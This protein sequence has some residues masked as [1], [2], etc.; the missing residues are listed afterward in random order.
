MPTRQEIEAKKAAVEAERQRRLETS[1]GKTSSSASPA[2]INLYTDGKGLDPEKKV[3]GTDL[4]TKKIHHL[5]PKNSSS[6]KNVAKQ[7]ASSKKPGSAPEKTGRKTTTPQSADYMRGQ[8]RSP[9]GEHEKGVPVTRVSG[10]GSVVMAQVGDNGQLKN[11]TYV[12]HQLSP[13]AD[14][15]LKISKDLIKK[16][17][18]DLGTNIAEKLANKTQQKSVQSLLDELARDVAAENQT[19]KGAAKISIDTIL[20]QIK[21]ENSQ[22]LNLA[23]NVAK[24]LNEPVNNTTWS[25]WKTL[26]VAVS[27]SEFATQFVSDFLTPEALEG[28]DSDQEFRQNIAEIED[29]QKKALNTKIGDSANSSEEQTILRNVTNLTKSY[30]KK[31]VREDRK[32]KEAELSYA[33][34]E[35][36]GLLQSAKERSALE[37]SVE[38]IQSDRYVLQTS[39]PDEAV[40]KFVIRKIA[41]KEADI[42]TLTQGS[43][44]FAERSLRLQQAAAMINQVTA[45]ISKETENRLAQEEAVLIS[46]VADKI[47]LLGRAK[48]KLTTDLPDTCEEVLSKVFNFADKTQPHAATLLNQ[49]RTNLILDNGFW[50]GDESIDGKSWIENDFIKGE[51]KKKSVIF[52]NLKTPEERR[53]AFEWILLEAPKA[54]AAIQ[55]ALKE[56]LVAADALK[57]K[58]EI[59]ALVTQVAKAFAP[60]GEAKKALIRSGDNSVQNALDGF[61]GGVSDTER[62]AISFLKEVYQHAGGEEDLESATKRYIQQGF[63][64]TGSGDGLFAKISEPEERKIAL[65]YLL[66][67]LPNAVSQVE[68]QA[69]KKSTAT[70][71]ADA[72]KALKEV[73]KSLKILGSTPSAESKSF[74]LSWGGVKTSLTEESAI[75]GFSVL[76]KYKSLY[77]LAIKPDAVEESCLE[78]LLNEDQK[79]NGELCRKIAE[80]AKADNAKLKQRINDEFERI[81]ASNFEKQKEKAVTKLKEFKALCSSLSKEDVTAIIE[82][83]FPDANTVV[84]QAGVER[85]PT[86]DPKGRYRITYELLSAIGKSSE[87]VEKLFDTAVVKVLSNNQNKLALAAYVIT[88]TDKVITALREKKIEKARPE[89]ESKVK[90]LLYGK[91]GVSGLAGEVFKKITGSPR[92]VIDCSSVKNELQNFLVRLGVVAEGDEINLE[93][94]GLLTKFPQ[95]KPVLLA[96]EM[97]TVVGNNPNLERKRK[98]AEVEGAFVQKIPDLL[99]GDNYKKEKLVDEV[100]VAGEPS[101]YRRSEI[102]EDEDLS[103]RD[104]TTQKQYAKLVAKQNN[105]LRRDGVQ[106]E[107]KDTTQFK[108]YKNQFLR[109]TYAAMEA[110]AAEEKEK[111][112]VLDETAASALSAEVKQLLT[113]AQSNLKALRDQKIELRHCGDEEDYLADLLRVSKNQTSEHRVKDWIEGELKKG[114]APESEVSAAVTPQK[115][116]PSSEVNTSPFLKKSDPKSEPESPKQAKEE[117]ELAINLIKEASEILG[118]VLEE[119]RKAEAKEAESI[120]GLAPEDQSLPAARPSTPDLSVLTLESDFPDVPDRLISK[121][122]V[123]GIDDVKSKESSS[124]THYYYAPILQNLETQEI[125]K[126]KFGEEGDRKYCFKVLNTE[127]QGKDLEYQKRAA[128]KEK[129][130]D[131]LK[132]TKEFQ[133]TSHGEGW[134]LTDQEIAIAILLADK[135][136]GFSEVG[137]IAGRKEELVTKDLRKLFPQCTDYADLFQKMHWFSSAFQALAGDNLRTG[138]L[139]TADAFNDVPLRLKRLTPDFARDLFVGELSQDSF[140]ENGALKSKLESKFAESLNEFEE[141]CKKI[142]FAKVLNI[143]EV[144][145]DV[146]SRPSSAVGD[147][148]GTPKSS[149]RDPSAESLGQTHKGNSPRSGSGS[150]GESLGQTRRS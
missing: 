124:E 122:A 67:Q 3:V 21:P 82:A 150:A 92:H 58:V 15:S 55:S 115:S 129:V 83:N 91:D 76:E 90:E 26:L 137:K 104:N 132:Q 120:V 68:E 8:D 27:Q 86:K 118:K 141:T 85:T 23:I 44:S 5:K 140:G 75:E 112:D 108:N 127:L 113:Q 102:T 123:V 51:S 101:K 84:S 145:E 74:G 14:N 134:A 107:A 135:H 28:E 146:V 50:S 39:V 6:G 103:G 88:E 93:D 136:D 10:E 89:I 77:D 34:D 117:L 2:A 99:S 53:G 149:P 1:Q 95:L 16:F 72:E 25:P 142:D 48:K 20:Q 114:V 64:T 79:T 121:F 46:K 80:R 62:A 38:E 96:I 133:K 7:P 9:R 63:T 139:E 54:T 143:T 69:K 49:I 70:N 60:L 65:E 17:L 130:K 105:F 32:K 31:M 78:G 4:F 98:I 19:T 52:Q 71:L 106:F 13:R 138:R 37:P 11:Q 56:S 42:Q 148:T 12:P 41:G 24:F 131:L 30:T 61:D 126:E 87:D 47:I 125:V 36:L 110:K 111:Q 22:A 144:A 40:K 128:I 18:E 100:V 73:F 81:D 35:A 119:K 59:Q 66:R 109:L 33:L 43:A 147:R 94:E 29:A 45:K 97:A 57:A 116:G